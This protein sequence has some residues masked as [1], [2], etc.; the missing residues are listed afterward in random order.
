[1]NQENKNEPIVERKNLHKTIL[2]F[3]YGKLE[4]LSKEDDDDGTAKANLAKLRRGL[5]GKIEHSPETWKFIYTGFDRNFEQFNRFEQRRIEDAV[6]TALCLFA[7]HAQGGKKAYEKT[8]SFAK[9]AGMMKSES[10]TKGKEEKEEGMN[11]RFAAMVSTGNLQRIT[12]HAKDITK[13]LKTENR[14]FNYA[15]FAADLYSLQSENQNVR[16]GILRKWGKD[17]WGREKKAEK[18]DVKQEI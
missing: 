4:N 8:I 18:N 11:R 17:Y 7:M 9:A 2:S 1:M 15:E 16:S 6:F 14:G 5:G 10:K 12:Y 3:M 13:L